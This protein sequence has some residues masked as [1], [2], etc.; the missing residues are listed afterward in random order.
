M[1][2]LENKKKLAAVSMVSLEEHPR[3]NISRETI[4]PRIS[5]EHITQVSEKIEGRVTKSISQ[6]FSTTENRITKALSKLDGFILN[7]Q[8]TV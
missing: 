2:T 5:E 7:P 1:A 6:G 4:V 3:N 8:G